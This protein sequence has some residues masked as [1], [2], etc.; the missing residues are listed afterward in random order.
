MKI[1][2]GTIN[3]KESVAPF[4]KNSM[5]FLEIKNK[6]IPSAAASSAPTCL[7]KEAVAKRNPAIN[8]EALSKLRFRQI[9]I[10]KEIGKI[11]K[12]SVN[13]KLPS[14]NR[15]EVKKPKIKVAISAFFSPKTFCD[16][17]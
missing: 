7:Y 9:S 3:P 6:Y 14:I 10:A 1:K 15:S 5:K 8:K 11:M 17:S 13:A 4:L 2:K 12:I 16:I